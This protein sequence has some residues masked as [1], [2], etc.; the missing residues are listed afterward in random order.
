V[1]VG[2]HVERCEHCAA[3]LDE[4][5]ERSPAPVE[6][7]PALLEALEPPIALERR[8]ASRIEARAANAASLQVVFDLLGVGW[9]TLKLL[10]EGDDARG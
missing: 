3:R 1:E 5:A 9:E 8:V 7:A 6:W 10:S 4:I 2:T